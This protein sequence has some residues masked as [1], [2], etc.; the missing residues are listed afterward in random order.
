MSINQM[1]P[2]VARNIQ[3]SVAFKFRAQDPET[4]RKMQSLGLNPK[5]LRSKYITA[6]SDTYY[7][8]KH[9][10]FGGDTRMRLREKL[11]RT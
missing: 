3:A 2:E 4:L 8:A 6:K 1:T 9:K 5:D 11:A 10:Q 7:S